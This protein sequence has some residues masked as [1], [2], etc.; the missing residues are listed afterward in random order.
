MERGIAAA[1]IDVIDAT[2]TRLEAEIA[3]L[4]AAA[5]LLA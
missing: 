3:Q 1:R 5:D 2:V 4:D